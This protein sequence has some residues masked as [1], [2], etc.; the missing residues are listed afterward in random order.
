MDELIFHASLA[1]VYAVAAA[2]AWRL[3]HRRLAWCYGC[4]AFLYLGFAA[5]HLPWPCARPQP[6]VP[7]ASALCHRQG[8][9]VRRDAGPHD[10]GKCYLYFAEG[11]H[12]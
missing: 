5:L 3:R 9:A 6:C 11:G 1:G 7:D 10:S 2:E 8:D 4:A 12:L